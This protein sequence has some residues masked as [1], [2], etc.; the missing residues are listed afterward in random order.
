MSKFVAVLVTWLGWLFC[1][2]GLHFVASTWG[3]IG[4]AVVGI[5]ITLYGITVLL[6]AVMNKNAIW[7]SGSSSALASRGK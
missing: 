7:K 2:A 3:R 4:V 6:P 1:M 5:A